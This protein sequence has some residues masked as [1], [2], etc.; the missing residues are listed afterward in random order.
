MHLELM[1]FPRDLVE[2]TLVDWLIGIV[3]VQNVDVEN[4][5]ESVNKPAQTHEALPT[6]YI[7]EFLF[8]VFCV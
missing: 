1:G 2:D 4:E 7:F 8:V 3:F 6:S 5:T